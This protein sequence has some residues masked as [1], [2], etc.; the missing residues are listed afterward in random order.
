[1]LKIIEREVV[2]Q[3]YVMRRALVL[4]ER[5]RSVPRHEPNAIDMTHGRSHFRLLQN[6]VDSY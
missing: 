2:R 6:D 3:F 5:W 4:V 1:M